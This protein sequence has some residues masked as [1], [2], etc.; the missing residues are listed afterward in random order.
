MVTMMGKCRRQ[1]CCAGAP[2]LCNVYLLFLI[3]RIFMVAAAVSNNFLRIT[4]SYL[5]PKTVVK[6]QDTSWHSPNKRSWGGTPSSTL[7]IHS[8]R[9]MPRVT[10]FG[11]HRFPR[12]ASPGA[13]PSGEQAPSASPAVPCRK[14]PRIMSLDQIPTLR[15]HTLHKLWALR[16][17]GAPKEQKESFISR[18]LGQLEG[19]QVHT[20]RSLNGQYA[21][22]RKSNP[23]VAKTHC[24]AMLPLKGMR[25]WPQRCL[26]SSTKFESIRGW[27]LAIS[28]PTNEQ[29]YAFQRFTK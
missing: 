24:T 21:T 4:R 1:T 25:Q 7:P 8:I 19:I 16:I 17:A 11:T 26:H 15:D 2:C 18:I 27:N 9:W 3:C 13:D 10:D 12:K 22:L 29:P 5:Q 20:N 28:W 23:I 14:A 6:W